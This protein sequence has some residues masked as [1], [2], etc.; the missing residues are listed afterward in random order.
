MNWRCPSERQRTK[1]RRELLIVCLL[2]VNPLI[3]GSDPPGL[4]PNL[5]FVALTDQRH[6]TLQSSEISQRLRNQEAPLTVELTFRGVPNQE[7]LQP[8]GLFIQCRKLYELALNL[9]EFRQRIKQQALVEAYRD[10][11]LFITAITQLG[12]IAGRNR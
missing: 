11:Q 2:F 10:N 3:T 8:L 6:P 1:L 7:T 12:A 9:F 4:V 5:E